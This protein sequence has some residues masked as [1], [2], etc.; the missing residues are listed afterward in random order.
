MPPLRECFGE[1]RCNA[2][3][4]KKVSEK[5]GDLINTP[6]LYVKLNDMKAMQWF[7]IS[8]TVMIFWCTL[9]VLA[10]TDSVEYEQY[11]YQQDSIWQEGYSAGWEAA[12]QQAPIPTYQHATSAPYPV[13][14]LVPV[15]PAVRYTGYT[16]QV[17]PYQ[18]PAYYQ[19][20][21]LVYAHQTVPVVRPVVIAP[22]Y[23]PYPVHRPHP[24]VRRRSPR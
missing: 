8:V 19:S 21:A 13:P 18:S 22:T 4:E 16:M 11:W 12:N 6:Y 2:E 9:P 23:R 20:A 1:T 17:Q 14:V 24:P 5:L 15:A 3:T 10:Q 7:K